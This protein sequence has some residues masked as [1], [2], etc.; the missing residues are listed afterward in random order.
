MAATWIEAAGAISGLLGTLL[1]AHNGRYAGL[2]F[3]VYLV[4]N[5][6]WM[7]FATAQG[8]WWML[9]QYV[10]FTGVSLYGVWRWLIRPPR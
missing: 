1:L 7:W 6:A 8:H 2:G 5:I 9:A 10:G 4:S 3:V